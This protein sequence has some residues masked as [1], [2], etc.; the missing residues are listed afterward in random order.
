MLWI[1]IAKI[2]NIKQFTKLFHL[3]YTKKLRPNYGTVVTTAL[4]LV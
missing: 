2:L 4:E 3:F 1:S